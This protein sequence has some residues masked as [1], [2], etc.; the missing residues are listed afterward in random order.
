MLLNR[1]L[2]HS[3]RGAAAESLSHSVS[4]FLIQIDQSFLKSFI[5]TNGFSW[6]SLTWVPSSHTEGFILTDTIKGSLGLS[7][8]DSGCRVGMHTSLCVLL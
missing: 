3:V 1:G 5:L 8:R 4:P 2:S 7:E 6:L